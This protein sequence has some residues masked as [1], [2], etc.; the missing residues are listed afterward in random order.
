MTGEPDSSSAVWD[1]AHRTLTLG[2]IL[3]VS[4]AA[5]ENLAVATILP[6][7]VDDI[8]GLDLY[9]WAFSA[10]MLAEIVGISLAGRAG[11]VRGLAPPFAVGSALFCAGLLGAGVAGSMPVLIACR[12]LQGLGGGAISALA[13]AAT[14]RGYG[15]AA[16]PHML[17][18]LSTAWVAPGL[19]GPA[20]AG[21]IAEQAGW[22]WVFLGLVPLSAVAMA[23]AVRAVRRLGPAAV[24]ADVPAGM[25]AAAAGLAAG[26]GALLWASGLDSGVAGVAAAVPAAALALAS[27]HR[28]TPAGTLRARPGLPAAILGMGVL[29]AAFFG[30]E[31]FIPLALTQVRER[32]VTIAGLA[33][34]AATI[35]WTTGAWVQARLAHRRS[36]RLLVAVGL[37]IMAAGIAAVAAVLLPSVPA[38]LAPVAW[39]VAGLGMGLAYSTTALVVMEC[40]APGEEGG[41]AAAMQL[42]NVLGTAIG[43][44][45]GGAV[46]ARISGHGG[47]IAT[48]I[49]LTD[50]LALLAAF[51]AAAIAVR[52]PASTPRLNT[53]PS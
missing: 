12:I 8:G 30:A 52:F 1:R 51:S 26:T 47:S 7:T 41:A 53:T 14:A 5:F 11:D 10:F 40:A 27:L 29:S 36:R 32:P 38:A 21:A 24:A 43:T 34:T 33:L 46:L 31:V 2:L 18:L 23:L 25:T 39:G 16:R 50:G 45:V 48:A 6:A 3:T 22:R 42:T 17:A 15:D 49:A 9:G 37:L 13:Y 19:I 35:T 20:L 28:L 44:G 4:M